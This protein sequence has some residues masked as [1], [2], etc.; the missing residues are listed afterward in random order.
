[1]PDLSQYFA[2]VLIMEEKLKDELRTRLPQ[3]L[4][5][6]ELLADPSA[7]ADELFTF[8]LNYARN[9]YLQIE[10]WGYQFAREINGGKPVVQAD[11][12]PTD[13]GLRKL[14]DAAG[15]VISKFMLDFEATVSRMRDSGMSDEAVRA[16]L[17]G[18]LVPLRLSPLFSS[19][20]QGL[21]QAVAVG[22]QHVA[23]T[24]LVQSLAATEGQPNAEDEEWVWVTVEDNRVC[25]DCQPRH[26]QIKTLLEWEQI[27]M[28]KSGW[29]VCD[30]RCRCIIMPAVFASENLD[31]S[32]PI[33]LDRAAVIAI[34]ERAAD[35]ARRV[36]TRIARW[37]GFYLNW[38]SQ[39]RGLAVI[40]KRAAALAEME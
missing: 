3:A 14:A 2:R 38:H 34:G 8:I 12:V 9:P 22:V 7:V 5:V 26:N 32:Q 10:S 37:F 4:D 11:S 16:S 35:L 6:D 15:L 19:L 30:E 27:G 39:P 40:A 25:N 18:G 17:E 24:A 31:M 23:N 36:I 1:M 28:P 20:V 29:S 21:A 13:E 33:Q